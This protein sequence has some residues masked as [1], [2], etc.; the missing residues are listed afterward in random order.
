[1]IDKPEKICPYCA[2]RVRGNN[3]SILEV[4][5]ALHVKKHELQGDEL[6]E[7]I[8]RK[9]ARG[10]LAISS[11]FFSAVGFADGEW[12]VKLVN[13]RIG[14]ELATILICALASLKIILP[15][16]APR[17][18]GL[19]RRA[20]YFGLDWTFSIV[21]GG[22]GKAWYNLFQALIPFYQNPWIILVL[23]LYFGLVLDVMAMKHIFLGRSRWSWGR[24]I[25]VR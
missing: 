8:F 25:W 18:V 11:V 3:S 20:V 6:N 4:N 19:F 23:I 22:L 1:M 5:Y 10:I 2:R 15:L 12:L 24:F 16:R 13:T 7:T 17:V 21:I 14:L 9:T